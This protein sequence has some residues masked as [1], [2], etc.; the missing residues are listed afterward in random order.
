MPLLIT[1]DAPKFS[2]R[3][4]MLVLVSWFLSTGS[5]SVFAQ[6]P[7]LF[8]GR[9]MGPI[10]YTVR[11]AESEVS[12]D[13]G[14][15]I[16]DSLDE[17]NRLMSTYQETSDISR[18]NQSTSTDWFSVDPLTAHVVEKSLALSAATDGA[19]DITVR[20]AVERWKF[21]TDKTDLQIPS[22]EEL[23]ILQTRIGYQKL[24]VRQSPPA[25]KKSQPDVQ[26]DLSAIAKG[27]AVDRVAERL[28]EH[29]IQNYMVE[30]GGE[31]AV[32]GKKA[33][34]SA[35]TIGIEKPVASQ[36]ELE[37]VLE[38]TDRA[39]ASSG[40]YR[41]FYVVEGTRYSHTIDPR[42]AQPVTWPPEE[43]VAAVSV[44]T[45]DCMTADALATALMVLGSD[46]GLSRAEAAG[47]TGLV[48][49]RRE[50]GTFECRVSEQFPA[51]VTRSTSPPKKA[52][53]LSTMAFAALI[54]VIA[55]TAMSVG[56]I[57]AGK[58]IK[59]SCGGIAALESG[60][61]DPVCSLC[62]SPRKQCQE[63]KQAI[64]E[65][66]QQEQVES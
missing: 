8:Q 27:F 32:R 42:T 6:E 34:G 65:R 10:Q 43:E 51:S 9:T 63:L 46:P 18:F 60:Q 22:A 4:A 66:A 16:Q 52:D 19:F 54:F 41:N 15:V 62:S 17:I 49:L 23:S 57:F 45:A 24:A 38:L 1:F 33:D 50:N 56:V 26:I 21:G 55:I 11:V 29:G 25:I 44:V 20:P 59:G 39:L 53:F 3:I 31:V 5:R 7:T 61:I 14:K 28:Q 37:R 35:W 36:R 12:N 58:R 13:L 30:V 47:A 64:Q 2:W 40:D 48:F